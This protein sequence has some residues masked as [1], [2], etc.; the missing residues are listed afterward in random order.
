MNKPINIIA[1]IANA[2]QGDPALAIKLARAAVES[3]ADSI[4][5]QI[6]SA[7]ELLT[8]NHPKFTHFREQAFGPEIWDWL[9]PE[10]KGLGV[11]VYADVFGLEALE[12][13][14]KH[15]LNGVK[16]HS[17]DLINSKLLDQIAYFEGKVFLAVGGSSLME[18][19]YALDHIEKFNRPS[20]IILMHGFQAY[21]TEIEDS[22]L[23]RL[24]C[25]NELFSNRLSIGYM[26]HVDADDSFNIILPLLSIP[27]GVRYLEKHITFNR[28]AKGVDYYSSLEPEEFCQFIDY[29]RLA[30]TAVGS[31]PL[32]FSVSEKR[33]RDTVK[34][35]WVLTRS[36]K[37]GD[38]IKDDDLIMKRS[39]ENIAPPFFEEIIGRKI[40]HSLKE[41]ESISKNCVQHNVLAVIVARSQSSRL[42]GK[43]MAELA[44]EPA[45]AH[46]LMR[47]LRAK[48]AGSVNNIAFCTTSDE[49]DDELA[50]FVS[51]FPVNVYR[52][53]VENVLSRMMLAVNDFNDHDTI[54]RITGDDV[55]IDS[56]YL[57]KT[58]KHHLMTNADYTNAK[59]LPSGT[60]VEVF[61]ATALQLILEL[62][63][64][65][66][67]TE[68]LTNYIIDNSSQFKI[69]TLPIPGKHKLDY[70]LTIDTEEDFSLVSSM[71]D[72]FKLIGKHYSYNMDDIIEFME[73]NPELASVNKH[74]QQRT[75][76]ISIDS[77]FQWVGYTTTPM[78]TVYIT[79]HN[80]EKY[81]RHSIDSVLSQNFSSYELIIIDDGSTDNSRDIIKEYSRNSK[82]KIVFQKNKGLNATNNI[83]LDLARGKYIMRLDADDYL[84]KNALFLMSN[85]LERNKDIVM[86]FPDYYMVDK[87][88]QIISHEHRHDFSNDVSLYD[89]PAHGA[90]SM[91]LTEILKE[92]GGY[93]ESY[94]CQDGYELWIKI[95]NHYKVGNINL[96]LFSYR[97]HGKNL[98]SNSDRI[99]KTRCSII[100]DYTENNNLSLEHN[101]C[102]I[103]I[104]SNDENELLSLKP[105][106]G[107]TLLE[108][109]IKQVQESHN[110]TKIILT[111]NSHTISNYAQY[112]KIDNLLV[113]VRSDGLASL[114]TPIDETV[115]YLLDEYG[116]QL[117]SLDTISIINYEYPMRDSKYI[118]KLIDVLSVYS[119]D[120]SI[121]VSEEKSNFYH[122]SGLGLKPLSTNTNL[123]L[124]RD[125]L[126]K[127]TGGLH[128]VRYDSFL[129]TGKISSEC[130]THIILDES[131]SFKIETRNDFD[132]LEF[133][134]QKK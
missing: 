34:K 1:E 35:S 9:L 89:Q 57:D 29:V 78:V 85:H 115:S 58:V 71:L 134:Y 39:K 64:D 73:S 118:D 121:S 90:C 97:Q 3:G 53:E 102:I 86:V 10:V 70:R 42:P 51:N 60:E 108:I 63:N 48:D 77:G 68:Y 52:G 113:D 88:G 129:K 124:E 5:F 36:K 126:Y 26:D 49:S 13:A 32:D 81:I 69:S 101:L 107:T 119:A 65:S 22:K 47:V 125:I 6:Y 11:E 14:K 112:L 8:R 92:V 59:D 80:Y 28:G 95:I 45:I 132:F 16:V 2:H 131:S 103:P 31:N 54:L 76:P 116:E 104:R 17:S 93:S 46:L 122:H 106:A 127:E 117:G 100:R 38:V 105:F 74:I 87:D 62:S 43:A 91:A 96:P 55:L 15:H 128:C 7:H 40:T 123:H 56:F 44:G 23:Q 83:A 37:K 114:N 4:K 72:Y 24:K 61:D 94:T 20:E 19:R 66:N 111:T 33:Y 130:E 82:V 12:I 27:Y 120:S 21:P 109:I 84:H 110:I 18:I 50:E 98:T 41:E 133:L 25:L 67:G 79:S 75:K 99:L 30:T